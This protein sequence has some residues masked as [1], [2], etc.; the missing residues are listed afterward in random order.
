MGNPLEGLPRKR[1]VLAEEAECLALRGGITAPV[2]L[3]DRLLR[4]LVIGQEAVGATKQEMI[5]AGEGGV[6]Q[7]CQRLALRKK[8][9][10]DL[11]QPAEREERRGVAQA[12]IEASTI[13]L[14]GRQALHVTLRR[15]ECSHRLLVGVERDGLPREERQV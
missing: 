1:P 5:V 8:Q 2:C 13:A 3:A 12:Q 10:E 6:L 14:P 15:L 7:S 9:I 11:L 4:T